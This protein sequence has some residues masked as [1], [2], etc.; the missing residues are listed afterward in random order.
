ML[1][2]SQG[3][4]H[5]PPWHHPERLPTSSEFYINILF[6]YLNAFLSHHLKLKGE[7][8][9][10]LFICMNFNSHFINF[11]QIT[12]LQSRCDFTD[13][14]VGH[15]TLF[16][17]DRNSALSRS[18]PTSLLLPQSS[19]LLVLAMVKFYKQHTKELSGIEA[20][21]HSLPSR[22]VNQL[23]KWFI[24]GEK[25]WLKLSQP[26]GAEW[27]KVSLMASSQGTAPCW[28]TVPKEWGRKRW[29]MLSGG[30]SSQHGGAEQSAFL[31]C[32]HSR[33]AW[34]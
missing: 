26:K 13:T 19:T 28:A 27:L 20:W 10:A 23:L 3:S 7:Q 32:S 15:V 34:M 33:T 25:A 17:Q 9:T 5:L 6:L 1:S 16:L 12:V 11:W 2:L 30:S 18:V 14:T 31:L 24:K 29:R 21:S 22:R 4:T 8:E